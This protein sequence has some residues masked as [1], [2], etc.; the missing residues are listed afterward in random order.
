[1]LAVADT[2]PGVLLMDTCPAGVRGAL[3]DPQAR[4][5]VDDGLMVV[6]LGNAH[7]FAALVRGA[8][9]YGL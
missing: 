8:R 5:R 4:E 3:L 2:L 1:M 6:N 7:T 9:L